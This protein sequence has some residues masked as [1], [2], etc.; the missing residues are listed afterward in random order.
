MT[1]AVVEPIAGRNV[2][3]GADEQ[4]IEGKQTLLIGEPR[5]GHGDVAKLRLTG[6]RV[7]QRACTVRAGIRQYHA[8]DVRRVRIDGE[9]RLLSEVFGG[10]D[11]EPSGPTV[12]TRSASSKVYC[13]K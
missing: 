3:L 7:K 5:L 11:H 6:Q 13:G 2:G 1:F 12:T 10:V 4:V 8:L 9:D